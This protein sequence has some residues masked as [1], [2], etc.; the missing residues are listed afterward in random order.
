MSQLFTWG[1]QSTGV[2]ALASF[3]PRNPRADLLQNGLVGSPCSPRD[4]QESS[5]T[6]QSKSINS[7]VLSFLYSPTLTSIHDYW[8]NIP[9]TIQ[10]FVYKVMSLLFNTQS[11]FV[12]AF[13]PRSKCLLIS[14]QQSA[15]A[16]ILDPQIKCITVSIVSP[17]ICHEVMGPDA[18]IFIFW[19]LSFKPTFSLSLSLSS[20]GFWVPLHFLP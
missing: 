20:R 6:P 17:S 9:L 2:S 5:P 4:S 13:L 11:R 1:G 3:L 15:S 18:M 10:T 7:L 16:V 8:K 19:M 14:C 12:T